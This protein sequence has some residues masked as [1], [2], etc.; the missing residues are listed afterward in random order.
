MH[1]VMLS[2]N[3]LVLFIG[4]TTQKKATRCKASINL[5]NWI[6]TNSSGF[7]VNI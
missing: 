1:F 3:N 6:V 4:T 2:R 5:Q 7:W